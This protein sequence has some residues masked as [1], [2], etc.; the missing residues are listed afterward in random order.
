[1][2]QGHPLNFL[3]V[4]ALTNIVLDFLFVGQFSFGVQGAGI[5][6]AIS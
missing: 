5:A 1:M 2:T 3:I 4:A 6:T